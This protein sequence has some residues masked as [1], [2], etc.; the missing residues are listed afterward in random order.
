MPD[1]GFVGTSY[2]APSIYQSD[3]EAICFFAEIDPT[4]TQG[5]RGVV[6]LYPTPGL[7]EQIQLPVTSAVRGMFVM[8]G[9]QYF[10]TVCGADVFK[11]DASYNY[12]KVGTLSTSTGYVSISDNQTTTGLI[13]IGRAHV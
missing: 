5:N 3:Q 10:V 2:T 4:K 7:V 11:V 8:S 12:T 6:A 1:F 13:E 9:G